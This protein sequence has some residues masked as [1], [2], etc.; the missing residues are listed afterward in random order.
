M[1]SASRMDAAL[2]AFRHYA[3]SKGYGIVAENDVPSGRQVKVKDGQSLVPVNFYTTGT[4]QV[5]GKSCAL[6]ADLE[7]W[8]QQYKSAGSSTKPV[9][10]DS[11]TTAAQVAINRTAR[12][13][14]APDHIDSTRE[15]LAAF[16]AEITQLT[17][18]AHLVYRATARR[19]AEKA[20]ASQYRT[21]T[22]M[23][24]GRGG[25]LFEE[26]CRLLEGELSQSFAE[27]GA[28]YVPDSDRTAALEYLNKPEAEQDALAWTYEY[29]GQEV[30]G[31]LPGTDREGYLSGTSVFLWLREGRRH[32]PD[33]STIVMPFARAYEG[34]VIHLAVE[35]A[36]ASEADVRGNVDQIRAGQYLD[37]I[38]EKVVKADKSRYTGLAD[39][40]L[41]AWRDI[42]NKVMHSDPQNP[43]PHR[44]LSHAEGDIM[45]LNRAMRQGY[46]YLVNRGIIAPKVDSKPSHEYIAVSADIESLRQALG[47]EGFTIRSTDGAKWIAEA[48]DLKVV[49]PSSPQG[50]VRVIA[51]ALEAF[52][53]KYA[54]YLKLQP[55]TVGS[56]VSAP[57]VAAKPKPQVAVQARIGLDES[58]KGD[59]FGPLIVGAVYVDEKTEATLL[60]MGVRDSKKISDRRISELAEAIKGLCPHSVVHIGPKRYNELYDKIG[61]LNKLLAWG[62]A[63]ALENVLKVQTCS[64]AVADQFGDEAFLRNALLQE[65][66]KITLEQRT[67]GEQ[68]TAVAAASILARAE[69][70]NQLERLTRQ[71]RVPLLKGSSN[72]EII[73]IAQRIAHEGGQPALAQVAKLHFKTTS[74]VMAKR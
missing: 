32:L 15:M 51:T 42:R 27:R 29:L 4:I 30:F 5:Q 72:P 31:F 71:F 13:H 67:K 41:S 44:S 1:T 21:G 45:S 52:K 66:R 74:A 19:A 24:Q 47:N 7:D 23:V 61:N 16:G 53:Q 8:H 25:D 55:D 49:C 62:H 33:Y 58:G 48:G 36:I 68:D 50:E 14:V 65:G 46:E 18:D 6:R 12:F 34:F 10:S 22:I 20:I 37:Q 2:E 60:A 28:R 63:R 64:L 73:A 35:L 11:P 9:P 56:K 26:I 57:P 39:T 3:Q 69:F 38:R 59:Y 54:Q 43:P 40:L 17:S 70:V